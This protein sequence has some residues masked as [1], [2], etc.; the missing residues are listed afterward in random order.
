MAKLNQII[1]IEKGIKSRA[2][3]ELTELNKIIQKPDL[4][5]GATRSYAP[6]DED[7]E[8]LPTE[9]KHVQYKAS[10]I[11]DKVSASLGDLM[12]VTARKDWSNCSAKATVSVDGKDV[13]TDAPVTYLLFLEKQLNDVRTFIGN[14]PTLD[15]SEQWSTD[16]NTNLFKTDAIAANRT[17]KVQKPIV[18]YHATAEHPAQTQVITEDV[19]VGSW[20]TIRQSG[21][22]PKPK[23]EAIINRVDKL[24]RAVKQAREEANGADEVQAQSVGSAVFNYLMEG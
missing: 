16:P 1:A 17:K 10:D 22:M 19:I 11:L 6:R 12:D 18:L 5:N 20:S 3:A 14:L 15:E 23:K 21:A 24:L 7:G 2:Y 8:T 13:I 4:F 9:R